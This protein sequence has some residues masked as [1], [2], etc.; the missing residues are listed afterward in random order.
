LKIRK[1]EGYQN[2]DKSEFDSPSVL[3][4]DD[5]K[6]EQIWKD[7][8]SLSDL[9][10]DKEFKSYDELKKRLDKVLGLNGEAPKTTVEQVKA[11]EFSAPKKQAEDS[12]FKDSAEDDDMAYFSKLA[13]ED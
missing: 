2:Y 10:G 4:D 8:F 5:A 1:V 6:L 11:K 13:E 12:P 7:S 3:S 9:T